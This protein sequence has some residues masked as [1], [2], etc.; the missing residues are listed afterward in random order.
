MSSKFL[1]FKLFIF[2]QDINPIPNERIREVINKLP[3]F[4]PQKQQK[5]EV[6]FNNNEFAQRVVDSF[7][8]YSLDRKWVIDIQKQEIR[9]IYNHAYPEDKYSLEEFRDS[10]CMYLSTINEIFGYKNYSRLGFII[11]SISN[12]ASFIDNENIED[13]L[14]EKTSRLVNRQN[15]NSISEKVNIVKET[16]YSKDLKIRVVQLDKVNVIPLA[17][18][19]FT[20]IFDFN[21][22]VELTDNRFSLN[23]TK[24]FLEEIET[25]SQT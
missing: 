18:L 10:A 21:T 6:E 19:E 2:N 3:N 11:E 25:K 15:F 12:D 5:V 4:L 14:I 17:N 20:K 22:Q 9:I 1:S 16:T 7:L 8:L 24:E 23:K 13:N